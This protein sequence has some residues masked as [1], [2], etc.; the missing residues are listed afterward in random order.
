MLGNTI[1]VDNTFPSLLAGGGTNT[2]KIQAGYVTVPAGQT[3][4]TPPT[5]VGGSQTI[6][7]TGTVDGTVGSFSN[8]MTGFTIET[9]TPQE[10][11]W[12]FIN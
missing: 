3:L 8:N 2:G 6:L 4:I 11:F 10:V 1:N 5:I 12:V 7:L 9:S